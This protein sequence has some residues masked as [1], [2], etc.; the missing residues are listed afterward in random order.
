MVANDTPSP[1]VPGPAERPSRYGRTAMIVLALAAGFAVTPRLTR[2][3]ETLSLD[4]AAP[5]FTGRLVANADAMIPVSS[6]AGVAPN[7]S[8]VFDL[9]S[10]RGHPVVLDFWATWCGPCQAELPVVNTVAQRYKDRGVAV[11]GINTS[12]EDGL[13]AY[14]VRKKGLGFP[15]VYDEGDSIAKKFGVTTLPTVIVISKTGKIAAIRHGLTSD[16][17]LDEIVRRYL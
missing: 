10:M 7:T 2:G 9:A 5:L 13:A 16:G 15:M 12:D 8:A 1:T 17:A 4:E 6:D 11:V 3:C 14:Y